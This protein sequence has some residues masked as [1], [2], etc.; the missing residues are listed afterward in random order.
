M[1]AQQLYFGPF[2][3]DFLTRRL[4]RGAEPVNL[5]PKALDLLLF[6]VQHPNEVLSREQILEAIWPGVFVDDHALSV[7]IGDLRKALGD[8][9]KTPAYIETRHRM[10]YAFVAAVRL[11]AAPAPVPPNSTTAERTDDAAPPFVGSAATPATHYARSGDINLAYQVLG[12][13]PIDLI[14]VMG[15]VSHLEYFWAEASFARF[16][17]RSPA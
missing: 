12:D 15:W 10:G 8:N 4:Y 14:F 3:L 5:P 9:S 16:L 7:Q 13:G 17:H 2:R 11:V 1:S 6:F